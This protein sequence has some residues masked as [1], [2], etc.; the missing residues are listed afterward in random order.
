MQ[1][2]LKTLTRERAW[3][4][5]H[6]HAMPMSVYSNW[7]IFLFNTKNITTA[8]LANDTVTHIDASVFKLSHW[9]ILFLHI[10]QPLPIFP[11]RKIVFTLI[12]SIFFVTQLA[13]HTKVYRHS[14]AIGLSWSYSRNTTEIQQTHITIANPSTFDA[15]QHPCKQSSSPFLCFDRFFYLVL[16]LCA[17]YT[18]VNS[19]MHGI[20]RWYIHVLQI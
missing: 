12:G 18:Y 19:G 15:Q 7:C 1:A 16:S 13:T 5:H 10:F 11:L 8:H 14:L 17:W 2:S 9:L 6:V 3:I 4:C 20:L